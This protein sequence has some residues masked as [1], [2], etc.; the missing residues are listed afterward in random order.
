MVP[1]TDGDILAVGDQ[2]PLV[3]RKIGTTGEVR[4]RRRFW[5]WLDGPDAAALAGGGSCV[6]S[7][8]YPGTSDTQELHLLRLN[9]D[10]AVQK[11]TRFHGHAAV[12]ATG[13]SG[14]C[15]VFYYDYLPG[16]MEE[17]R[18]HLTVFDASFNQQWTEGIPST[19]AG[20][21]GMSWYLIALRDGYLAGGNCLER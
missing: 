12:V 18:Y 15:A 11:Q 21:S 2:S 17:A 10:G 1:L 7:S 3:L 20:R 19:I 5:K 14:A 9:A 8:E 4:W 13:P 16:K 6:V